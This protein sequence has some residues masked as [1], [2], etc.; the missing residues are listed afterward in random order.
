MKSGSAVISQVHERAC[1][2][3]QSAFGLIYGLDPQERADGGGV[4][5]RVGADDRPVS[6]TSS[7]T[8]SRHL[9]FRDGNLGESFP[10]AAVP[11]DDVV[12]I[13]GKERFSE[14]SLST[15]T[16][17]CGGRKQNGP[18]NYVVD[19]VCSRGVSHGQQAVQQAFVEVGEQ[20]V[21]CC[22]VSHTC[23]SETES[24]LHFRAMG[25]LTKT[26]GHISQ[27]RLGKFIRLC[28]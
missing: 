7:S 27:R 14:L 9:E 18:A 2:D 28:E 13:R 24:S 20:V 22:R 1:I 26:I 4:G 10:Q 16:T 17:A 6:S 23:E 15:V 19:C 5:G 25:L 21:D 3:P 11:F 12:E 8:G